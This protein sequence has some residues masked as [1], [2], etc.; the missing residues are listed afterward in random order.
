MRRPHKLAASRSSEL[1][2]AA[3]WLDT[4]TRQLPIDARTVK[5][6]LCF[7]WLAYRRRVKG[8]AWSRPEWRRFETPEECWDLIE[9][10][11]RSKTRTYLFAHNLGFDLPVVDAFNVLPTRG[12]EL[13]RA[14]IDGP[15]TILSWRR[16][17]RTILA[18]DTLNI[19]RMPLDK[20]GEQVGLD[21]LPMPDAWADP[22][23]WDTYC[24]RDVEVIMAACLAWFDFLD[25]HRLGGFANTLAAQALKAY[26]HRFMPPGI[27]IDDHAPAI[28]LARSAYVGGRTECFRLGRIDGPLHLLDVN[29]MYP[30]VMKA[31][32]MPTRLIGYTERAEVSDL[33]RWLESRAVVADVSIHT[34][35]PMA[36]IVRE[37]RLVFPVGRF[38]AALATPELRPLLKAGAIEAVHAA[39][40][41][42]RGLIFSAFVDEL[43]QL[44]LDAEAA[45]DSVTA[46]QAKILLNSLYGKFG[47]RGRVYETFAHTDDL[48]PR[49][50]AEFD[51]V[52]GALRKFRQLAGAVQEQIDEP[53]ARDSHP[54][55]AAHV[56]AAGRAYL[57]QLFLAAG[58]ENVFYTD[59]DSL[60]TNDQGRDRLHAFCHPTALGALKVDRS[61]PYAHLFGP[62]DYDFAG[63]KKTKGVRRAALWIDSAT[64]EQDQWSSLA[65][66]VAKGSL[67]TPTTRR[68][69]KRLARAYT[70]GHVH[71]DGRVSPFHLGD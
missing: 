21:K 6:V 31:E 1:P 42:E 24:R 2:Q 51:A 63:R 15:P 33:H 44:R 18:V 5:H 68:V 25:R 55:I 37:G 45:G 60:L 54:A 61:M 9:S 17:G 29:S 62:K 40:V 8:G 16:D 26:R 50:W 43:Y 11:C 57:W 41:Y 71:P 36:P 13:G 32:P 56:T 7:G 28:A 14:V 12:W 34:D 53:E 58:R 22:A 39:A 19:W 10:L 20:L 64:V 3:I 30:H 35:H 65:A 4:E 48:T 69:V 27:Y 38:R 67:S 49:V 66:L 59:T 70:K 47:Q 52:T 23:E 46:L